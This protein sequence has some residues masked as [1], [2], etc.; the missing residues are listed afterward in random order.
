MPITQVRPATKLT[1][2]AEYICLNAAEWSSESYNAD[3]TKLPT[4]VDIDVKDNADSYESYASGTVYDTDT[5]VVSKEITTTQAAF[6]DLLIAQLKGETTTTNGI[7]M[8]GGVAARPY[9]A[10]GIVVMKKGG[11][12]DL[13]WYPKC[14][15]TEASDSTKTSTDSHSDQTDSLTIKAYAFNDDMNVDVRAVGVSGITE[16]EFFTAPLL[17]Q[18]AVAALASSGTGT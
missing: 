5:Q 7:I 16:E 12:L 8:E 9:F 14:K 13:R 2:G 4:V 17:T 10:Y 11:E 18:A 15:L 6:P 3:V 1:V